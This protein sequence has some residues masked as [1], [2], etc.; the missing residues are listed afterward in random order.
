M[1]PAPPHVLTDQI[2]HLRLVSKLTY[3]EI[4]IRLKVPQDKVWRICNPEAAREAGRRVTHRQKEHRRSDDVLKR[5]KI[6]LATMRSRAKELGYLPCTAS[7]ED[8]ASCYTG[9]CD[10]CGIPEPPTKPLCIEHCHTT[11]AFRGW[12]CHKCNIVVA[13]CNEDIEVLKKVISYLETPREQGA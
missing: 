5:V 3:K 12:V 8:I 9:I 10:I 1:K 7:A 4:S 6:R 13:Y 11:G 2:V